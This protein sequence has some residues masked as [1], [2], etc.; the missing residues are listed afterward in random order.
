MNRL[1]AVLCLRYANTVPN[2]RSRIAFVKVCSGTFERNKP[3]YHTRL[4]KTFRI[5]SV[6]F[7]AAKEVIDE[8]YAGD[9]VGIPDTGNFI[10]E[11]LTE[12]ET[13]F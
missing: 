4:G 5:S 8:A 10:I 11:T 9:I 6:A 1:S 12:G 3:Y 7:M 2:H 13:S